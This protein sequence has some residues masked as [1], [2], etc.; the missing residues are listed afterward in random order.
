MSEESKVAEQRNIV[1]ILLLIG[2]QRSL[3]R[4]VKTLMKILS[5][6]YKL[7]QNMLLLA[8]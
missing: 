2:M 6:Q 5:K 1:S 7:L 8:S 4:K 3:E